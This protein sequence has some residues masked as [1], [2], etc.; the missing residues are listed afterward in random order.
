MN[1][2]IEENKMKL[3]HVENAD[4]VASMNQNGSRSILVMNILNIPI[5]LN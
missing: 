3:C 5:N 2:T 1:G 4:L